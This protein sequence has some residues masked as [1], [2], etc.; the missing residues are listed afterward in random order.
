MQ[1]DRKSLVWALAALLMVGSLAGGLVIAQSGRT[2]PPSSPTATVSNIAAPALGPMIPA[3]G[4]SPIVKMAGPSVVSITSTTMRAA[5]ANDDNDPFSFF[6]GIPGF[7]F[8]NSPQTPR[9]EKAAG[10]G[11]IVSP[12]GYILT[13]NHVVDDATKVRVT[14]ADKREFDAKVIGKDKKSDVAVIK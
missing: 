6:G 2:A 8:R 4:F 14:L 12:D 7:N 1:R 11:V 5:A 13:N 3:A 10:S 9:R